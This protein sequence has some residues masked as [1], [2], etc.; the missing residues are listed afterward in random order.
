MNNKDDIALIPNFVLDTFYN[1]IQRCI[2]ENTN[3]DMYIKN[4]LKLN[5]NKLP[6]KIK[7]LIDAQ[8]RNIK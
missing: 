1:Q 7:I 8:T 2:K 4:I 3:Y 6:N 5:N